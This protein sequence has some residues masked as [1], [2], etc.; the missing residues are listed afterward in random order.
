MEHQHICCFEELMMKVK[1]DQNSKHGKEFE[2]KFQQLIKDCQTER[3]SRKRQRSST[4]EQ[5]MS[6]Q[7]EMSNASSSSKDDE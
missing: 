5:L 3:A 4:S 7:N 2:T 1:E 6:I